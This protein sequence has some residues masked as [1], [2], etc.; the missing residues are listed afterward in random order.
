MLTSAYAVASVA[1]NEFSI[2]LWISTL[3]GSVVQRS[4]AFYTH[5]LC[6]KGEGM[7]WI[8]PPWAVPAAA[9]LLSALAFFFLIS[10][11]CLFFLVILPNQAAVSGLHANTLLHWCAPFCCSCTS[12]KSTGIQFFTLKEGSPSLHTCH[13]IKCVFQTCFFF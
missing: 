2:K 9:A 10:P 3:L 5:L 1:M 11:L 4:G 6:V 7:T 8:S 13:G 12:T